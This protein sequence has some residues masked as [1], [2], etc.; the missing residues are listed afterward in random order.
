[1]EISIKQ[2]RVAPGKII[3]QVKRGMNVIITYRG[4]P[5]VKIIPVFER[6]T[7]ESIG[8]NDIFGMWKDRKDIKNVGQYV[9]N[10]REGRKF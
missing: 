7:A 10:I 1:M 9:R 8:E 6:E 2:L 5:S 3:S 4:K